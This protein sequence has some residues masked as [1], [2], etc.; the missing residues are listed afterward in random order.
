MVGR[1]LGVVAVQSA[2]L[3]AV[4]GGGHSTDVGRVFAKVAR[5]SQ[6]SEREEK[7][8]KSSEEL[9]FD[10]LQIFLKKMLEKSG[11]LCLTVLLCYASNLLC[12]R[13]G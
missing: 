6:G 8:G 13:T 10:R 3:S 2:L 5:A 7:R 4:I 9:H 1:E 12:K 11:A